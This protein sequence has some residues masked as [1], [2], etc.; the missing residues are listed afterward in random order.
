MSHVC[1]CHGKEHLFDVVL[2]C[3]DGTAMAYHVDT[4]GDL[5]QSLVDISPSAGMG[6]CGVAAVLNGRPCSDAFM[7]RALRATGIARVMALAY[8]PIGSLAG[9]GFFIEG[10]QRCTGAPDA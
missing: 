3:T 8:G 10:P 7:A 4:Y 1:S 9:E 2:V 6:I 5:V